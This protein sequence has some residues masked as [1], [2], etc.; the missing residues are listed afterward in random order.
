[1]NTKIILMLATAAFVLASESRADFTSGDFNYQSNGTGVTIT[2]YLGGSGT[3]TI[4]SALGGLPVTEIGDRAFWSN[5]TIT[6]VSLPSSVSIIG[7]AAF[8]NCIKLTNIN[9]SDIRNITTIQHWAFLNSPV[10]NYIPYSYICYGTNASIV[11]YNGTNNSL[12]IPPY[13]NGQPVTYIANEAFW[14][15]GLVS[16]VIPQSVTAL[17]A[18]AF[19]YDYGLTNVILLN[20]NT[21]IP[22][23]TPQSAGDPFEGIVPRPVI[24]YSL[25]LTPVITTD[26]F[27]TGSNQLTIDFVAIGNPGNSNDTTGYGEVPYTYRIGKYDISAQQITNALKIGANWSGDQPGTMSWYGAAAFVNWLNSS[28]GYPPAYNLLLSNGVW[29]M[30]LWPTTPDSNGNVAWTLGGTNLYRNANCAY[31]LPSENEWYKAAYYDPAKNG[32]SGGYWL[33]P[34]GSDIAPTPVKSGTN[35]GTAVFNGQ[36][37][38]ASVFQAGGLSPY[39]TMGQGG[40]VWQWMESAFDGGNTDP[41]GY[42]TFRG[43]NYP[44]S[45]EF[46]SSTNRNK[47]PPDYPTFDF[48]FRIASID[49]SW[50]SNGL[51]AYYPFNGDARDYSGNGRDASLLF[52]NGWGFTDGLIGFS[53]NC[54]NNGN[55]TFGCYGSNNTPLVAN[56]FSVSEWLYIPSSNSYTNEWVYLFSGWGDFFLR[57]PISVSSNSVLNSF[58]IGSG[59]QNN[60]WDLQSKYSIPLNEWFHVVVTHKNNSC[61]IY[62]NGVLL[63][64]FNGS[65]TLDINNFVIG[66]S[67]GYQYPFVGK[68][69]EVRIY[70][71]SLSSNEVA[72]LYELDGGV[73]PPSLSTQT[74]LFPDPSPV[75]YGVPPITL[76]ATASSGLPVNFTSISTNINISGNIVTVLGTGT[77]TIVASQSGNSTYAAAPSV[78]NTLVVNGPDSRKKTQTIT[79]SALKPKAWTNAPFALTAKA[80]SMLPITYTSSDASVATVSN[81]ILTPVGV[82]I[83]TITAYQGG[84]TIYN[85]ATPVSQPQLITQASQKITFP[86]IASHTYGDAPFTLSATSTSRLP[87]TYTS[88]TPSVV[89]VS[90]NVVTIVGVGTAKITASQGG[91]ALYTAATAV[92]QSFKVIKANQTVTFSQTSPLTYTFGGIIPFGATASSRLPITYTSSKAS[93][94]TIANG[95]AQ[96]LMLSKGTA[97]ITATQSGNANYNKASATATITV[98]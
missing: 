47:I 67:G 86:T 82:G 59:N 18:R 85:P 57:I 4:P 87:I 63:S 75:T 78:T 51:V 32:G 97:T 27:G 79:F 28:A 30:R 83:T 19:G 49:D 33:Y 17:G 12:I 31:F 14:E 16:V 38:P 60:H 95:L 10:G 2:R 76:T 74:I 45:A 42:R 15:Q 44:L 6:S 23:T 70:N 24:S 58:D 25:P 65:N 35:P 96:G 55:V 91:N 53:L 69:D 98:Q 29:S 71:R 21:I 90:G 8:Y 39:G 7:E 94:I 40:N 41:S 89:T 3:L 43:G 5:T 84:N 73:L 13:I 1:M 37:Y 61:S 66:N 46:L 26:T 56:N 80:S 72:G 11:G 48:G 88:L 34:T 22:I 52:N 93:V 20:S 77:A 81:G 9:I 68:I 92:S 54:E 36:P 64:S 50:L 62:I